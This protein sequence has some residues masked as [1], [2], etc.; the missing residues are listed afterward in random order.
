MSD[1]NFYRAFE[2]RYRGSRELIKGRLKV[3]LPFI[4]PLVSPDQPCSAVDLGCGRGE[5]LETLGEIGISALGIDLDEGMLSACSE[6]GLKVVHGDAIAYLGSLDDESQLVVSAFHM[7]EHISF[8]QLR[9]LVQE[10]HRVLKPGGLLIMET[11]NPEN[12][13]VATCSFYLDPTHN[14]PIPPDLLLFITEFYNFFRSKI[15]RLQEWSEITKLTSLNLN[16]VLGGASPD[17]AVIAQK[18]AK[19]DI[20]SKCDDAFAAEYG[21]DAK[22]LA[23]RYSDQQNQKF[24][25]LQSGLEQAEQT[26]ISIYSSFSWRVTR[27]IRWLGKQRRKL[28]EEGIKARFRVVAKKIYFRTLGRITLI[29][30]PESPFRRALYWVRDCLGYYPSKINNVGSIKIA[31]ELS[32]GAQ[33]IYLKLSK[34]GSNAHSN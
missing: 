34:V 32:I 27:P 14:K 20:L 21:V 15:L 19:F 22:T 4:E 9:H 26:V 23:S 18:A 24:Q 31:D 17:Y 5:W 6:R 7:V 33:K 16:D 28:K 1:Q 25:S 12:I 13:M 8:D 3:Y 29:K 11:P 10:A 2:D 30:D